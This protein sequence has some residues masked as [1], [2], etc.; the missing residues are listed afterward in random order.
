MGEYTSAR[1]TSPPAVDS[2]VCGGDHHPSAAGAAAAAAVCFFSSV[3]F[4]GGERAEFPRPGAGQTFGR[5]ALLR[6]DGFDETREQ[7]LASFI[8]LNAQFDED[9]KSDNKIGHTFLFFFI[10]RLVYSL[11]HFIGVIS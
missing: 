2:R 4:L 8:R 1:T 3:A 10:H 7:G 6:D 9:P 5:L 11:V